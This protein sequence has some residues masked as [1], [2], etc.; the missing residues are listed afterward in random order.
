MCEYTKRIKV[1]ASEILAHVFILAD[2]N[3]CFFI[4]FCVSLVND[5]A[6]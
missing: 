4:F 1:Y 3:V 5:R 2:E 6:H